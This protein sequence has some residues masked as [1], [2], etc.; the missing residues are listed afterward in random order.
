MAE[1]YKARRKAD[2]EE[3]Y[4][5][6]VQAGMQGALRYTSIGVGLAILGHYT[7]PTFRYVI[8]RVTR[9]E[10][11]LMSMQTTNACIQSVPCNGL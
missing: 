6:Q 9:L 11:V 10:R 3:A 4:N 5:V 8:S 1:S 2:V 7:W